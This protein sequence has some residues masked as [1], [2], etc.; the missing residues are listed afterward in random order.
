MA[1]DDVEAQ[2]MRELETRLEAAGREVLPPAILSI[3]LLPVGGHYDPPEGSGFDIDDVTWVV[4]W[5]GTMKD[6]SGARCLFIIR[7]AFL[8]ADRTGQLYGES[9]HEVVR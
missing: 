8:I 4:E 3:T 5:E 2:A 1:A 7:G 6:C 9:Y